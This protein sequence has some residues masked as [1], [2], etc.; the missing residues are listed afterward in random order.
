VSP[1]FENLMLTRRFVNYTR[2]DPNVL[3]PLVDE[4]VG[5]FRLFHLEE[6]LVHVIHSKF[7]P[8]GMLL[9]ELLIFVIGLL[10]H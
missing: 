7:L 10:F 3:C 5:V 4:V 1:V 9:F 6:G 2:V 8:F